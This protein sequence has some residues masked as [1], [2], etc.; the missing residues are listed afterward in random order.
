[1]TLSSAREAP[2]MKLLSVFTL[3]QG[4]LR[5]NWS[6]HSILPPSQSA[7][8]L[9]KKQNKIAAN[10]LHWEETD[11]SARLQCLLLNTILFQL[12]LSILVPVANQ[13]LGLST[14]FSLNCYQAKMVLFFKVLSLLFSGFQM[15]DSWTLVQADCNSFVLEVIYVGQL[16]FWRA[17]VA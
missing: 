9:Q 3:C 7:S 5:Y 4:K 1:M 8:T 14:K 17:V 12:K 6:Y 2:P 15:L 10:M 16:F 13:T 11:F